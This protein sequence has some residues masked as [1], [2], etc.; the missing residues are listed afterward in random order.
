MQTLPTPLD[1]SHKHVPHRVGLQRLRLAAQ[2]VIGDRGLF[3][4]PGCGSWPWAVTE[5]FNL[6]R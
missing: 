4:S 2:T 6:N 1:R 3:S 5:I